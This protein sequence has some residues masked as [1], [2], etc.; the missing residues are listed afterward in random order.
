MTLCSWVWVE[1]WKSVYNTL[2]KSKPLL[3]VYV[4]QGIKEIRHFCMQFRLLDLSTM[5]SIVNGWFH[6]SIFF[7][8]TVARQVNNSGQE[9]HYVCLAVSLSARDKALMVSTQEGKIVCKIVW[10]SC[11][12]QMPVLRFGYFKKDLCYA[13]T[14]ITVVQRLKKAM[15]FYTYTGVSLYGLS[16]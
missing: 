15:G 12:H 8:F 1:S 13:G 16:V 6:I 14:V 3:L 5:P 9:D 4:S 10:H 11:F 2:E 7:S